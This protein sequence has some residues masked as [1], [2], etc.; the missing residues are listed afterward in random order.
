ME[1]VGR[2][3]RLA[4]VHRLPGLGNLSAWGN[5]VSAE[6]KLGIDVLPQST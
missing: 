5:D 4:V 2:D 3:A 6:L 1:K